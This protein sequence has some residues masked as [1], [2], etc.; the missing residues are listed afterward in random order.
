[1][2]T[3][4]TLS[5]DETVISKAKQYAKKNKTSLSSLIENY[6]GQLTRKEKATKEEISP[7]VKDLIG[8]IKRPISKKQRR[9]EYTDYLKKKY[10]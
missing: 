8:V 7:L 1:M 3:K 10:K 5:L 6:L 9:D 2:D 4:L